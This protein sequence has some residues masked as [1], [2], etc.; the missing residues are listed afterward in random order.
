MAEPTSK[1]QQLVNSLAE[2][3][4]IAMR[5]L[6]E[7]QAVQTAVEFANLTT[8]VASLVARLEVLERMGGPGAK[9]ATRGERKTGGGAAKATTGDKYDKVINAMLYCRRMFADSAEFRAKYTC[10]ATTAGIEGDDKITKHPEGSEARHL[11]EGHLVWRKFLTS[12]QKKDIKDEFKR[13]QDDRKRTGI[14]AP[15]VADAAPPAADAPP[16]PTAAAA[17]ET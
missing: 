7:E 16:G 11:A 13:W 14:P 17:M 8:M 1:Q 4:V 12:Q 3:V 9:R 15:L 5:P 2:G 10:A 6:L